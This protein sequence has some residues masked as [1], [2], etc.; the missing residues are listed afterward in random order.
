MKITSA[1]YVKDSASGENVSITCTIDGMPNC[2]PL[3]DGN[4]DY[5]EI[6]K[7]VKEGTLTIKDAE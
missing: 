7:Q 1:Q 6:M 5:Q 2:V 3:S 4:T